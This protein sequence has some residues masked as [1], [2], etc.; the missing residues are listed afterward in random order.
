[1]AMPA[2]N[3]LDLK[4]FNG[5]IGA[6]ERYSIIKKM[7]KLIRK[8]TKLIITTFD[9]QPKRPASI[10]LNA[11]A[12]MLN[13]PISCPDISKLLLSFLVRGGLATYFIVNKNPT[14]P[15]GTFT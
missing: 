4:S 1:M 8:R 3:V 7:K 12:A 11:N 2:E 6:T 14:T 9:S 10:K 5:N 13:V 15:I